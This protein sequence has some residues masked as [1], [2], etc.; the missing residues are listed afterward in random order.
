M[1]LFHLIWRELPDWG[2]GGSSIRYYTVT[3]T[4]LTLYYS[5]GDLDGVYTKE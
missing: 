1:M 5:D 4:S 3:P 2:A